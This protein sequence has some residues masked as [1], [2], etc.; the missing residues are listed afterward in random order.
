[1]FSSMRRGLKSI[2]FYQAVPSELSEGTVSGAC[3]SIT[4]ITLLI[5]LV[6]VSIIN[7]TSPKKGSDLIV[8]QE[9]LDQKLRVNLDISFSKYPCSMLSLD[10][11]NI[12]K[13]HDVNIGQTISKFNLPDMTPFIETEDWT[14]KKKRVSEDFKSNKGCRMKGTF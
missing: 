4:S 11:E 10:V 5:V 12:L 9:H 13:V 3:I 8:D 7:F 1:M 14:E 6:S 2:D